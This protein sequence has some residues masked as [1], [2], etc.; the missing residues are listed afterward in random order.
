MKGLAKKRKKVRNFSPEKANNW[1]I[2]DSQSRSIKDDK[3]RRE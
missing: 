3:R 1:K 2:N